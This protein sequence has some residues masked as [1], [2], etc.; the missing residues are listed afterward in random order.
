MEVNELETMHLMMER[1]LHYIDA[2]NDERKKK[3]GKTREK[4]LREMRTCG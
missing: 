4:K 1:F 2:L 3:S